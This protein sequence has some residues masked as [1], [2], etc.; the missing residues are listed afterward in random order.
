MCS[1]LFFM[2]YYSMVSGKYITDIILTDNIVC[3]MLI[4]I[5]VAYRSI[6]S[7]YLPNTANI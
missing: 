2:S 6:N 7:R 1:T 5:I 3:H 4:Y